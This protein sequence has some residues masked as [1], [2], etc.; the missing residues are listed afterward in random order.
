M[1]GEAGKAQNRALGIL[2][3]DASGAAVGRESA[4]VAWHEIVNAYRTRK[5]LSGNLSGIE[6]L[7]GGWVV[8]GGIL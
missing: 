8:A 2:T 6:R 7:E 4:D 1:P 3:V 5:I